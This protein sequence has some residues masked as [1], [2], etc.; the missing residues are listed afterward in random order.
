M[1]KKWDFLK[2]VTDIDDRFIEEAAGEWI[3]PIRNVQQ[4]LVKIAACFA[5]IVSLLLSGVSFNPTARVM[6][7]NIRIKIDRILGS[8]EDLTSYAQILNTT[9]TV[10]D[11]DVTLENVILDEDTLYVLLDVNDKRESVNEDEDQ[12]DIAPSGSICINGKSMDGV[13]GNRSTEISH[14]L[15]EKGTEVLIKYVFDGYTFPEKIEKLKIPF[16]IIRYI[17]REYEAPDATV[18]GDVEFTFSASRKE[19][20]ASSKSVETDIKVKLRNNTEVQVQKIRVS[21]VASSIFVKCDKKFWGKSKVYMKGK[22]SKGNL[23]CY[24]GDLEYDKD[25]GGVYLYSNSEGFDP[26][27]ENEFE[28]G[29]ASY[30]IPLPDTDANSMELQFYFLDAIELEKD[31]DGTESFTYPYPTKHTVKPSG[32]KFAVYFK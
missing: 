5:I 20:Q 14:S 17:T 4:I 8:R 32:K 18:L 3:Q 9:K 29:N 23:V 26:E 7:E 15:G 10:A 6:A 11:V 27:E 24:G 2:E 13:M 31:E 21:K 25:A 1:S 28:K 19:L 22:D 16:K 12:V 30:S